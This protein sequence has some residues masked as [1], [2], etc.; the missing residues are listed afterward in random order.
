VLAGNALLHGIA[1]ELES[2]VMPVGTYIGATPPLGEERARALIANGM[3][4]ADVNW[5]LDY[6]RI[7]ADTRL[8]FGGAPRI[9]R[10]RRRTCAHHAARMRRVF[11]Q[12]ADTPIERVWGGFVDI[13][14]TARRTGAGSGATCSSRRASPATA[15]P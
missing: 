4:A 5:A 11:P 12:L 7:G 14:A 3:A 15:W 10:C 13:S 8:L 1:P 9:R 2:R 6:F